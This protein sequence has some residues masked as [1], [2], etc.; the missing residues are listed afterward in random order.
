[1]SSSVILVSVASST[2]AAACSTPRT[3]SPVAVAVATNRCAVPGSAMSP[4]S[5]TT[6]AP[7]AR[8]RSIVS[9][10]SGVGCEREDSTIRPQPAAAIF[11][12]KNSP[13]PPSPPVMR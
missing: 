6:S 7:I 1:M 3:G 10:A 2:T 11:S 8:M 5:T 12:A 13:R 9:S 4:H